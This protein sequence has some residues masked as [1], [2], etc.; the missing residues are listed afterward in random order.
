MAETMKFEATC[1]CGQ[2][3]TG[4]GTT[5]RHDSKPA[6]RHQPMPVGTLRQI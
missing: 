5:W 2:H 4:N 1:K 3:L 6:S